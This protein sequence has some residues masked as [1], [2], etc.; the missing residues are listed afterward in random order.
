MDKSIKD[1]LN[2]VDAEI[3]ITGNTHYPMHI[4][5]ENKIIINPGSVGQ[6]RDYIPGACWLFWDT[7]KDEFKFYRENYNFDNV[8]KMVEHYEPE[9]KYLSNVLQRTKK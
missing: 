2:K 8:I 6:P 3:I 9:N 7:V 4:E 5:L 1:K